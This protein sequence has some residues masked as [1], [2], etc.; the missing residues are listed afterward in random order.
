MNRV[1]RGLPLLRL[2][3]NTDGLRNQTER[4]RLPEVWRAHGCLDGRRVHHGI[5]TGCAADTLRPYHHGPEP[6]LDFI[7]YCDGTALH[8]IAAEQT[9]PVF[10]Q[11]LLQ[12]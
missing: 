1:G 5:E 9:A 12:Q 7:S 3:G 2:I 6:R 11:P 10:A 8:P 4:S